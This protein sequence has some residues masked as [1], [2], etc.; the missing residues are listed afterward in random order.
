VYCSDDNPAGIWHCVDECDQ[1][2]EVL[3]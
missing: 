2:S 1:P 3:T